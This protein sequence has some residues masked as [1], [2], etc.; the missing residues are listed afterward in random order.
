M[1][2]LTFAEMGPLMPA[3]LGWPL[4]QSDTEELIDP[5]GFVELCYLPTNGDLA[6]DAELQAVVEATM[7]DPRAWED[8]FNAGNGFGQR[9]ADYENDVTI[10]HQ[11]QS[12]SSEHDL[13]SDEKFDDSW[14]NEEYDP[15]SEA[16][17]LYNDP[18]DPGEQSPS[19]DQTCKILH[20]KLTRFFI[21]QPAS[22]LT[23]E[24]TYKAGA[25]ALDYV[26]NDYSG[27]SYANS[28]V[29]GSPLGFTSCDSCQ[30]DTQTALQNSWECQ[31]AVYFQSK[32]L[33]ASIALRFQHF[34]RIFGLDLRFKKRGLLF[35]AQSRLRQFIENFNQ[36][37]RQNE[38][39]IS[40]QPTIVQQCMCTVGFLMVALSSRVCNVKDISQRLRIH[41]WL[42]EE[43]GVL[44]ESV[45]CTDP[46]HVCD[47]DN[48]MRTSSESK[49]ALTL[50]RLMSDDGASTSP[51][52]PPISSMITR[53]CRHP[54]VDIVQLQRKAAS[55]MVALFA[56]RA[57]YAS[58]MK[59]ET[60]DGPMYKSPQVLTPVSCLDLVS[61]DDQVLPSSR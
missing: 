44:P 49:A 22:P 36:A 5:D 45:H 54:E 32:F 10:A 25:M 60:A 58:C 46:Y 11:M 38:Y 53:A 21:L 50:C 56:A 29:L 20:L 31:W 47:C 59:C 55:G 3:D 17:D 8:A 6:T 27:C 42:T 35:E 51:E 9:P 18:D 30:A 12:S 40:E 48:L 13:A 24:Q 41:Q 52:P 19:D 14:A 2:L 43:L 15:F 16:L 26:V 1:K 61:R 28:K 7:T 34:A 39:K 4:R 57:V 23:C 33:R 37:C